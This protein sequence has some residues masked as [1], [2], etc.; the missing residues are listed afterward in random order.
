MKPPKRY[1]RFSFWLCAF[2]AAAYLGILYSKLS[3][4]NVYDRDGWLVCMLLGA[5]FLTAAI[6]LFLRN[7]ASDRAWEQY[8]ADRVET[9]R[10]LREKLQAEQ[11]EKKARREEFDR[12]HGR[13]FTKVA[14]VTFDNED[15]SSRQRILKAAMAEECCG[16]VTLER[17]EFKGR[18]AIRV[19]YDG[20]CIGS[21]PRDRVAEILPVL[22]RITAGAL[23]VSRFVPEDEDEKTAFAGGVIY[24]ADLSLVYE[25]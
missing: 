13:I 16:T 3:S 14:G 6:L 21:I 11:D 22:D 10:L 20:A 17:Y 4:S 19:E 5:V 9:E 25:K 23:E 24:R 8:E 2:L 12:T 1:K 15:G 18:D 7:R